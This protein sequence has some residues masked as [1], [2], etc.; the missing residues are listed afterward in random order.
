MK[1]NL[2]RDSRGCLD[3]EDLQKFRLNKE[4]LA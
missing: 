1:D 2:I 3:V 4:N